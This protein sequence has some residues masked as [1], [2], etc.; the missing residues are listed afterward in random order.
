VGGLA[1]RLTQLE[2]LEACGVTAC[3]TDAVPALRARADWILPGGDGTAV[4]E[5]ITA[6]VLKG[7]LNLA[8]SPRHRLAI[9]W[10]AGSSEPVTVP[11]RGVN[12]LI[13]RDPLSGE[14]WLAAALVDAHPGR[15]WEIPVGTAER[16]QPETATRHPVG[17]RMVAAGR[18]L[19]LLRAASER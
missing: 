8:R 12:V 14:S 17:G 2:A 16:T 9:G 7:R 10:A 6:D 4:A 15:E 18:S 3:P 13:P 11:A 19:R 1:T 5:A